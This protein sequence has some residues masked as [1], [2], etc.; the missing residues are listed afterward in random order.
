VSKQGHGGARDGV[1]R[2][3]LSGCEAEGHRECVPVLVGKVDQPVEQRMQNLVEPGEAQIT[4]ELRAGRPQ[5]AD[6]SVDG[7]RRCGMQERALAD[8]C[9]SGDE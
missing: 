8:T 4:L 2:R 9:F 5:Y 7:S 6:A 3:G 1:P